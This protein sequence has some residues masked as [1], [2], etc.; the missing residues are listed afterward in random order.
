MGATIGPDGWLYV[1]EGA[2]GQITRINP[3][4]GE[5]ETFASGLPKAVLPIGGAIDV[6][7][8][9]KTAYALVTLVGP[10]VG[11]THTVGIY[12]VDDADSFTV[13]ADLGAF[14]IAHPPPHSMVVP[15]GLQ[16]AL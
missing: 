5:T 3:K 7:F 13:I 9:G 16:F 6:A 4:N 8:I 15:S 10:D 1:T 14:S 12:R 11:G 2:L